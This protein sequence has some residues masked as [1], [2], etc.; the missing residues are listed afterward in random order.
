MSTVGQAQGIVLGSYCRCAVSLHMHLC[1]VAG[2]DL[3]V[4]RLCSVSQPTSDYD[5]GTV[6]VR[7][8]WA[9]ATTVHAGDP[10]MMWQSAG[11]QGNALGLQQAMAAQAAQE[12]QQQGSPLQ[13]R[14]C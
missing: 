7:P 2:V 6:C 14:P 12:Q 8:A 1:V 11:A 4:K 9:E 3:P 5:M 10:R 13:V